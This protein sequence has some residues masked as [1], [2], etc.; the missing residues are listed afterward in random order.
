MFG[1]KSQDTEKKKKKIQV[2]SARA[3]A[4]VG[5]GII[6]IVIFFSDLFAASYL[7]E[8]LASPATCARG[9]LSSLM[10]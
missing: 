1:V 8:C 10:A 7:V 6:L 9:R 2:P 5:H 4:N 3:V